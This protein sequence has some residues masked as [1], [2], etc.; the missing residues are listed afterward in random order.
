MSDLIFLLLTAGFFAAAM[1]FV[2]WLDRLD[3]PRAP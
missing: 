3:R 1:A 2:A